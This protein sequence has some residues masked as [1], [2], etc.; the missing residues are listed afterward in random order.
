MADTP[1]GQEKKSG[2]GVE[3]EPW[4][5][6]E[7]C[8]RKV[9]EVFEDEEVAVWYKRAMNLGLITF[10]LC[11]FG[12]V[13][14]EICGFWNVPG[15]FHMVPAIKPY[16]GSGLDMTL[17]SIIVILTI[18]MSLISLLIGV[19]DENENCVGGALG[20]N[21]I[22]ILLNVGL[23]Y[24][25]VMID[26]EIKEKLHACW[27]AMGCSA[28]RDATMP[29]KKPKDNNN[30]QVGNYEFSDEDDNVKTQV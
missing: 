8:W 16:C 21:G 5:F 28:P 23:G 27:R 24:I 17:W 3:E 13:I 4:W 30:N 2:A 14:P 9:D 6:R 12:L 18:L 11:F 20:V 7:N 26:P 25:L 29:E 15:L 1:R 19:S 22:I 10:V